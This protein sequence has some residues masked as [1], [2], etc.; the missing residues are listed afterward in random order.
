MFD[1]LQKRFIRSSL[2]LNPPPVTLSS[3]RSPLV[4][5]CRMD[6]S[7]RKTAAHFKKNDSIGCS[8]A[9]KETCSNKVKIKNKIGKAEIR[10][11][12]TLY[13]Q[14]TCRYVDMAMGFKCLGNILVCTERCK[15]SLSI[16]ESLMT[17]EL[18]V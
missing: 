8:V 2:S 18:R 17:F 14:P 9:S 7:K 5:V 4:S 13:F 1:A 11:R 10:F 15:D 3:A 6:N 12:F 16:Q